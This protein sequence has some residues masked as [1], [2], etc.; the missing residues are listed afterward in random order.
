MAKVA[1]TLLALLFA[2]YC[3]WDGRGVACP[4]GVLAPNEPVQ[5]LVKD[6]PRWELDGGIRLQALAR[7]EVEARV[8]GA[9]RYRMDREAALS[10]VDLALGWGPMSA[11]ENL[12]PLSI[13]QG[14][15]FYRY[16]WSSY[17]DLRIPSQEIARHSANMH[18]VPL[19]PGVRETLL[20]ARRGNLVKLTGW[21]VE[22][23][24]PNGFVWKSSLTRNDTG[25]GACELVAVESV[26]LR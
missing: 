20:R 9:E 15:R 13:S 12:E 21:L 4:P 17:S 1:L 18:M 26:E 7:F 25:A 14:G 22:A 2:G 8:L 23:R 11:N 10:P 16:S 24:S 5:Q 3:W 6:G 19:D